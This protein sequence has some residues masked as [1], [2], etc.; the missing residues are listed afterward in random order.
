[1]AVC[2]WANRFNRTMCHCIASLLAELSSMR[3][4][5]AAAI[6]FFPTLNYVIGCCRRSDSFY[7]SI[8]NTI[9]IWFN[10]LLR[11]QD[12]L[13]HERTGNNDDYS[14]AKEQKVKN[15]NDD[16]QSP[17]PSKSRKTGKIEST[18]PI[19]YCSKK[20][21]I[22]TRLLLVVFSFHLNQQNGTTDFHF[23]RIAKTNCLYW[24]FEI[25]ISIKKPDKIFHS[26]I[27]D[28]FDVIFFFVSRLDWITHI[29]RR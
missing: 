4:M 28:Y 27:I 14:Y 25:L 18:E 5:L 24:E 3:R 21:N 10:A 13:K 7:R 29:E 12:S 17:P 1:M 11:A 15:E 9:W 20:R 6:D 16:D 19:V 2:R 8:T 26:L 23:S 22:Q